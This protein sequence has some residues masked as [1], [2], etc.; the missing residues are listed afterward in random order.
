MR[1]GCC[2]LL[3]CARTTLPKLPDAQKKMLRPSGASISP[4][5]IDH[6]FHRQPGLVAAQVVD[7]RFG[8]RVCLRGAGDEHGHVGEQDALEAMG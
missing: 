8:G 6:A 1:S 7:Q 2:G 3:P 4:R 5:A